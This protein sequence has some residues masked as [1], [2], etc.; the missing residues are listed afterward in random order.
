[1]KWQI[2]FSADKCR[3]MHMGKYNL[4]FTCTVMGSEMNI[5][6]QERDLGVTINSAIKMSAQCSAAKRKQP[7]Y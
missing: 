7:K 2:K 1:M 5:T 6:T 4:N 3:V